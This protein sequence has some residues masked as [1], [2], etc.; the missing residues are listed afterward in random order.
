MSQSGLLCEYCSQIPLDPILLNFESRRSSSRARSYRL[1]TGLRIKRSSCPLCRLVLSHLSDDFRAAKYPKEVYLTWLCGPDNRWGFQASES[2]IDSRIGFSSRITPHNSKNPEVK[3]KYFIEPLT[4][5]VVDTTRII[6]WISLCE[7]YH[8]SKCAMPTNLAFEEAFRGLHVLRLLDVRSNCLVE[9][10]SLEKYVALSYVWGAVSNFRLT[11]ANRAALLAQGSLT[12]VS[13]Q[14]PNTIKDAIILVRRLDCRYLW[15]DALCLIQND[16][17]DL[18]VGVNVMDLIYERAWLTVIAGC[19]HDA[20]A[21]LPGVQEGT[22]KSSDNTVEV[23][24]GVEMGVVTG[25]DGL[26]QSS[27]YDSRAWTFQEQVL[28]RRCLYFIDNKVFFRCRAAQHA[29][30]FV[31]IW[32]S[33][34]VGVSLGSMLPQARLMAN[35]ELDLSLMLFYYAKRA[36]T[37]QNDASRALA[38]ITSRIAEA[39]KCRFFQGLPTAMFD[40]FIVF[41]A[42]GTILHRRSSFPSYSWTGWRGS[43][44]VELDSHGIITNEWL[45]NRTWIVWYKRSRS[46]VT[47]LV[48]DPDANPLFPLGDMKRT[49]PSERVFFSRALPSYPLLQFWTISLFYKIIEIDVFKATGYL[50]D[51]NQ[52]N[53]GFVWL[54]GFEETTLFESHDPCE[55][56]L[57]S[58]A[59]SH[60][61]LDY[62]GVQWQ[63]PYPLTVGQWTFYNVLLLEWQGGIAER[64]GFGVLHQSAIRYSMAPGPSWKEIFLS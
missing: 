61:F 59:Y 1:G 18:E 11:K 9:R 5:S 22:R 30:H 27:V 6:G 24:P 14:L 50:S 19:G 39:M 4:D 34:H 12:R 56:I 32:L 52:M 60:P 29:E 7:Q 10:T 57:L 48:W 42:Y 55:I 36:L 47:N 37:S 2:G 33:S 41:K 58:E 13:G 62:E 40:R 15:V 17:E 38:G 54:D 20:N 31:D 53:C 49:M 51:S 25:L 43:I 16:A 8:G 21:R 35:P 64:R 46:G 23:I 44:D 63:H 3:S 28:S 26:L 45:K